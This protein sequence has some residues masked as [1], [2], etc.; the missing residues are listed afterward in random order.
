MQDFDSRGDIAPRRPAALI[1]GGN[2]GIGRATA[3]ELARLGYAVLITSRQAER[4]VAAVER[5]RRESGSDAVEW[6]SLDL[7]DFASV[8]ACAAGLI[9][10]GQRLDVLI[11]NAGTIRSKR[12]LSVDGNELTFQVNHLGHFLLTTLL[13]DGLEVA[14]PSR[15][16]NV[17]SEMHAR[18]RGGLDFD[19]LQMERRY[20][21]MRA[22]SHSKLANIYFS[23]ALS[24]RLGADGAT[25]NAVHPGGVRTELGSDGE[26][27][28][29]TG[30]SWWLMK[31]VLRSPGSGARPV[32]RLATSDDVAGVSGAYFARMKQQT[33]RGVAA[34][35]EAAERLWTA[36][37]Q[38][39]ATGRDARQ[40]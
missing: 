8:R 26:F 22:Y 17:S 6:L 2:A 37:E 9:E 36:S 19:D 34:D 21:A 1:T 35:A 38:L 3:I 20:G 7:S 10:R 28:G 18:A 4:G 25:A 33:L 16:I 15:I 27:G 32:V 14:G 24:R 31:W 23:Q 11:N 40:S 39:V 12:A 30:A 13:L 5:I 29:I